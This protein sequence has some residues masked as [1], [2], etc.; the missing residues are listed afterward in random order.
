[1]LRSYIDTM[2]LDEFPQLL[3]IVDQEKYISAIPALDVDHPKFDWIFR[4]MDFEQWNTTTN[5]RLLWLSGPLERNIHQVSSYVVGQEKNAT[6]KADHFVLYFFCSTVTT[7]RSI[8]AAFVHTLFNQILCSSPRDER[9]LIIKSFLY[10]L[11]EEL[12]K[13]E[14]SPDW[15]ER[16]FSEND[17]PDVSVLK[18]LN[19]PAGELWAALKAILGTEQKRGMSLVVDGLDKVEHHGGEFFEGFREFVEHLQ[20]RFSQVKIL[21]TSTKIKSLFDGLP[22]IEYDKERQG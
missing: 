9:M 18:M 2:N 13:K 17:S 11:L 21:L 6:S 7:T 5:S 8:V 16:G 22:Y 4:N 15:K 1:M 3:S 12:F 14:A 20:H 19:A 10:N